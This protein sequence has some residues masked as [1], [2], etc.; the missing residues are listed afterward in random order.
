MALLAEVIV[1]TTEERFGAAEMTLPGDVLVPMLLTIE[2]PTAYLFDC[3][4][5][6]N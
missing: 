1:A 4:C 5:L 6:A 3:A 2:L